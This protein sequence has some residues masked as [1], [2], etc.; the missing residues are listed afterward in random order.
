MGGNVVLSLRR[1]ADDACVGRLRGGALGGAVAGRARG[2][3]ARPRPGPAA[4]AGLQPARRQ[5]LAAEHARRPRRRC[6]VRAGRA[7][8]PSPWSARPSLLVAPAMLGGFDLGTRRRLRG[9]RQRRP[10][11]PA[12]A[13][14]RCRRSTR[15]RPP[16]GSPGRSPSCCGRAWA[17]PRPSELGAV[18][19]RAARRRPGAL[20]VVLVRRRRRARLAH[21]RRG[22]RAHAPGPRPD[23]EPLPQPLGRAV[24]GRPRTDV[25]RAAR[26][27]LGARRARAHA[28]RAV[29]SAGG[30]WSTAT[31]CRARRTPSPTSCWPAWCWCPTPPPRPAPAVRSCWPRR[32]SG[33]SAVPRCAPGCA[34][35]Y[36]PR[37]WRG[38]CR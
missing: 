18:P 37:A 20:A 2:G 17:S 7:P 3:P 23:R 34:S 30:R 16:G 4:R 21:P 31:C 26:P 11:S 13:S 32:S 9:R 19:E 38:C 6:C 14:R 12:W 24:V 5:R 27:P 25:R 36:A 8:P 10:R 22:R 33:C 28:T 35:S 1:L 15:A 29:R